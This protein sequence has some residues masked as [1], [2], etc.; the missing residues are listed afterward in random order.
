MKRQR[1]RYQSGFS[2]VELIVVMVLIGI[3]GGVLSLQLAPAIRSYL[4]VGQ[5]A[6]LTS[7][8]DTA[9]RTIVGEVRSAVPNS[10]RL[11][12][13]QCLDLV[14]TKDG[15]RFRTGPDTDN[16][17]VTGAFLD[18]SG[19]TDRFDVLTP[20]GNPPLDGDA[21]VIG[22][23]NTGDVY[24]Q[25]NVGIVDG[26]HT[27]PAS[28]AVTGMSGVRLR[29][30]IQIPPGYDGGR[31]LIVPAAEKVVTY[32]CDQVG[33]TGGTGTGTLYRFAS[34]QFHNT[35]TC[36]IPANRAIVA[37]K[38][39]HCAF[40]YSPNQGATQENGFV[41]LQLTLSDKG[42]AAPLTLGAHVDNMP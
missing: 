31:F 2:L 30:P 1:A 24:H 26:P 39:S 37:T 38:V 4:L 41:Q 12:N 33:E 17:A 16:G 9:L 5:R 13:A 21:I 14:P 29:A 8:A 28:S 11:R 42:E 6:A 22:N 32:A 40:I 36:A 35:A 25:V 3:I 10:L 23:Q 34:N 19:P 20:L 7:Q 15:G 27:G 18:A